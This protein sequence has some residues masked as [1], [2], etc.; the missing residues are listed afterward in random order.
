MQGCRHHAE[1]ESSK[2]FCPFLCVKHNDEL[3]LYLIYVRSKK[4]VEQE[5]IEKYQFPLRDEYV[6]CDAN[7]AG[8]PFALSVSRKIKARVFFKSQNRAFVLDRVSIQPNSDHQ[9]HIP[10]HQGNYVQNFCSMGC[11][12]M[13]KDFDERKR[14]ALI[15]ERLEFS[16][17]MTKITDNTVLEEGHFHQRRM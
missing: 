10:A 4:Y 14:L 2:T 9:V 6:A 7:I 12:Q 16:K 11:M 3:I 1:Q 15:A 8:C 5:A 13:R 17:R